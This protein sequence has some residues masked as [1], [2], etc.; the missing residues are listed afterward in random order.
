VASLLR[1]VTPGTAGAAYQ[2]RA[3]HASVFINN[4]G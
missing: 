1:E 3:S 4:D 2:G